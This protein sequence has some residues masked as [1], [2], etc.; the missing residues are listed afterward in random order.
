MPGF[1][2]STILSYSNLQILGLRVGSSNAPLQGSMGG[3]SAPYNS[4]PYGG[5]HI[6]PSSPLLDG[7]HQHSARSNI[8][9]TSIGAGSQ[10]LPYYSM[11]VGSTLFS[12]FDVFGN[13]AFSSGSISIRGNPS[14]GQQNPV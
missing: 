9:H 2:T 8:N 14:Y 13:N 4:F 7:P 3:T 12:M 5:G 11:S 1:D 6:P 10:E